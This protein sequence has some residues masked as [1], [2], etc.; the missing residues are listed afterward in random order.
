M[1]YLVYS[2]STVDPMYSFFRFNQMFTLIIMLLENELADQKLHSANVLF[3]L[4][5]LFVDKN[6]AFESW[7]QQKC[8]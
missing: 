4:K 1:N 5:E 6:A 7:E 8:I 3:Y 2:Q